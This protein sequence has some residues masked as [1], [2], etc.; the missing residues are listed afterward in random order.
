M[1]HAPVSVAKILAFSPNNAV[2]KNFTDQV[3]KQLQFIGE[4]IGVDDNDKLER[5]MIAN[6]QVIAGINFHH[7]SVRMIDTHL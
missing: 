3:N 7:P 2:F 4:A 1:K 5:T 6:K